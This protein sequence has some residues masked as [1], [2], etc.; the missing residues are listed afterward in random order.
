[1]PA[2]RS[3]VSVL[4]RE[5]IDVGGIPEGD[6]QLDG[7]TEERLG[8]LV[9]QGPQVRAGALRIAVAHT[10]Q[11]DP[12]DLQ[13]RRARPY[14]LHRSL[15]C[16]RGR[17][18]PMVAMILDREVERRMPDLPRA[19]HPGGFNGLLSRMVRAN[20]NPESLIFTDYWQAYKR[21]GTSPR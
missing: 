7:L 10:A 14:V 8:L 5:L 9:I 21:S 13:R 16:Q 18:L 2:F 11:R 6:T 15:S 17:G 3:V 12:A 19:P 4:L 20:V 1:M